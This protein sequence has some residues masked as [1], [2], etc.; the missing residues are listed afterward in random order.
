MLLAAAGRTGRPASSAWTWPTDRPLA[1]LI[2]P[3]AAAYLAVVVLDEVADPAGDR[4][5]QPGQPAQPSVSG[6]LGPAAGQRHRPLPGDPGHR[7]LILQ[8]DPSLL[9]VVPPLVLSLHLGVLVPAAQ[10]R[11]ATGLAAAGP[12]HRRAQRRRPR[13]RC[14]RT[15]VHQAAELFSADEVEVELHDG[16]ADRPRRQRQR[17]RFDGPTAE[18]PPAQRH[19]SSP[20]PLQGHDGTEIGRAPAP[21]PRPGAAL[22]TRA[23]HPAYLRLRAL[24]RDPQRV[25]VRRTDPGRRRAR[26]R[27]VARRTHRPGQ[28][29]AAAGPG[30]R[31]ARACGTPTASPRCC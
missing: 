4:A 6:Q 23:V 30:H 2:V 3:L 25:G 13:G 24:H 7:W 8:V 14:C 29:P 5:R 12:D 10:P 20:P 1:E 22:R 18:P 17:S 9:L 15:A 21:V 16:G 19:R 27:G 31:T 11:G 26:A 28:P